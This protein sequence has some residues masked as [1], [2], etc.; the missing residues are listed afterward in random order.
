M[1]S[2]NNL[3]VTF[4]IFTSESHHCHHR[5]HCHSTWVMWAEISSLQCL[6][7]HLKRTLSG[8]IILNHRQLQ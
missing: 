7:V 4:K 6:E 1:M 3:I 8:P 2:V 5:F